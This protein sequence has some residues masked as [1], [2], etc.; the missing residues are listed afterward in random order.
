MYSVDAEL[1]KPAYDDT[2]AVLTSTEEFR[3][4]V[5]GDIIKRLDFIRKVGNNAAHRDKKI[6]P[7]QV[8]LCLENLFVFLDLVA[9][10]YSDEYE[11]KK[12]NPELLNIRTDKTEPTVSVIDFEKLAEENQKLRAQLTARR[13]EQQKLI[14]RLRSRLNTVRVNCT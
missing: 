11:E 13:E 5:G 10:F 3:K 1:Q 9:Y 14:F 2:F 8:K 6:S 4:I 12:Y 7:E